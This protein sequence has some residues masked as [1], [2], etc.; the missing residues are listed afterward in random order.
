MFPLTSYAL[1]S[2]PQSL[3]LIQSIEVAARSPV[4]EPANEAL[5]ERAVEAAPAN[6]PYYYYPNGKQAKRGEAKPPAYYYYPNGKQGK[7]AVELAERG[8][9]KPPNVPYYY[10]PNGKQAKRAVEG[11]DDYI[12]YIYVPEKPAAQE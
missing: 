4:A 11:A 3:T 10:Y 12:Y 1:Y 7:R 2:R 9:A 5:V 6:V 8:E